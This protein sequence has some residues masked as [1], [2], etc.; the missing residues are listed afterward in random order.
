MTQETKHQPPVMPMQ[1]WQ[2]ID[3]RF[4]RYILVRGILS[5]GKAMVSTCSRD[6]TKVKSRKTKV[7]LHRFNGKAKGYIFVGKFED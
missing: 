2:E 3:K 7:S 6:G 4:E 5:N 1:I